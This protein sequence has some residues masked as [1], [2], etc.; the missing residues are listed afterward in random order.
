MSKNKALLGILLMVLG[1]AILSSKDGIVKTVVDQVGPFQILW[2]QFAGSF[3]VMALVSLP[4]HGWKVILPSSPGA[5]FV[6]G[7]LNVGAVSAFF[8]ALK[9]IPLADATAL[10]LFA[11]VVATVLSPFVLGEKIGLLRITAAAFGFCGVIVMLRPGFAGDPTGYYIGLTAGILLG[12]YF[13]ANRRL[14]GS[15]HFLLNITHNTLMGALALTPVM[16]FV[17]EPVPAA[18]YWEFAF[19]IGLGVI[20]QGCLISSFKYGPAAVISPYS[21]TML[22]FSAL[23]GYL[24]FDTVPDAISWLG[25]VLIVGSGVYIA[26]R[27]RQL[28]KGQ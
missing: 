6:R 2:I 27:E 25:I 28:A 20:G 9:Y 22:L 15:Q 23:I 13:M 8:F 1:S 4:S 19:I 3:L 24:V 10:L 12:C 26:H 5:Q 17:W 7:A 16:L 18:V 11:P 21:Y 14:A